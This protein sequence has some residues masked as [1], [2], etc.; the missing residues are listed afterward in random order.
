MRYGKAMLLGSVALFSVATAAHAETYKPDCF[1]PAPGV[2]K[3]IQLPAKEGPFRVALVNGFAGN[4]WRINMIQAAKAWSAL[5]DV[6]PDLKEFKVVSVG[7][8]V[9]AQISAVDSLIA[10]GFDGIVINAVDPTSF[11]PVVKRAQ[12]SGVALLAFDN[13]L[14]TDAIVQLNESQ[15]ELGAVKARDVVRRI[16]DKKNPKVLEVRGLPG[17]SV[18]R[19]NHNGMREVLDKVP[20]IQVVEVVGNWDTGTVQKVVAD[21]IATHGAFDGIVCQHGCAGAVR[22][23]LDAKVPMAPLGGD[24]ENGTR[25]EMAANNV[26]GISA[27]QVPAMAAIAM[28]ELIAELK[29]NALPTMSFLPIPTVVSEDLKDGVNYF[30]NLPKTFYA[31]TG[32]KSCGLEFTSEQILG[33]TPDNM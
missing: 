13:V 7:N 32:F 17:N 27:G 30:S 6:K 16:G 8:D 21:A 12:K 18:D 1:A 29:G 15:T 33:Q 11:G 10:A 19:D 24:A 31:A 25:M 22:A 28:S 14:D 23:M 9:A 20:G 2:T 26:P 3:S 5:P 4:D